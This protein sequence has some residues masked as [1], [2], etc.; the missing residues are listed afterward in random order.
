[1][2]QARRPGVAEPCEWTEQAEL[3][4]APQDV[5]IPRDRASLD[6]P[7]FLARLTGEHRLCL[8]Y[9]YSKCASGRRGARNDYL[10]PI[11]PMRSQLTNAQL[12]GVARELPRDI[13][14]AVAIR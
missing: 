11:G 10:A 1:M 5:W 13:A 4:R 8:I 12:T 2:I 6:Q 14:Q 9:L 3:D 7:E